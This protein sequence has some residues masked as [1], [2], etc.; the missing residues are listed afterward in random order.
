MLLQPWYDG[1]AG[2]GGAAFDPATSRLILN[3]HNV[4]GPLK[5]SEVPAGS[6]NYG[7]YAR[8]CGSC[9]GA[10]R[11]GTDAGVALEGLRERMGP[12]E[13]AAI[14]NEGRG[15]MPGF[16]HLREGERTGILRYILAE[17]PIKDEPTADVSYAFCCY[18]YLRDDEELPGS[19]PPW[20]TLNSI[21]LAS[22]EIVWSVPF[23]NFPTHPNLG[24][25]AISYGGPVV[26]ASGLIFIAATPDAKFR[27]YD[28][29]DGALLWETELSAAGFSTPAVYSVAG[30]QYVAIAAG[31]GRT[32]VPSGADYFAFRL[33]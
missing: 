7:S 11:E 4:A 21:D 14:I 10:D 5:L 33:P 18:A 20:G 15:R 30:R 1:G 22:G 27:A 26:T 13:A 6:S 29:R 25:G 8:H 3:A 32:G 9:H 16:A 19:A 17:T 24:L 2:W 12:G 23:G 31:G 28:E